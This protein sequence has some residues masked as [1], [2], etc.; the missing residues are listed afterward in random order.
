MSTRRDFARG[1][2]VALGGLATGVT[3]AGDDEPPRPVTNA[4]GGPA[5]GPAGSDVGSLLSFIRSQ[6]VEGEFPL[7]FLRD[8]SGALPAWKSRARGKLVE[9]LH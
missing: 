7:S 3:N 6:A 5:P 9:L 2:A 4:H 8:E 1:V